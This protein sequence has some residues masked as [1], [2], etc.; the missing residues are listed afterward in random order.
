ML[1][2]SDV[3]LELL[4]ADAGQRS[5]RRIE[6]IREKRVREIERA[7]RAFQR[8]QIDRVVEAAREVVGQ[9]RSDADLVPALRKAIRRAW[10]RW[11]SA[12]DAAESARDVAHVHALRIATKRLRYRTELAAEV[13]MEPAR[14][15]L[16]RMEEIQEAIGRWHDRQV[17]RDVSATAGARR[18]RRR[19][20]AEMDDLL[21]FV[22]ARG[23][24]LPRRWARP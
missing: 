2:R 8:A 19:D 3:A 12:R 13:G 15:A 23:A 1:F 20:V 4:D 11:N 10:Q 16:K 21:R 5:S 18:R 6:R 9:C 14:R 24:S 17:L 7:R 22:R